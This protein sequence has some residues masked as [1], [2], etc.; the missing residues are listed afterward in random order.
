MAMWMMAAMIR[1]NF[2]SIIIER[3]MRYYLIM[4]SDP[5]RSEDDKPNQA[6]FSEEYLKHQL[7]K[8]DKMTIQ[9]LLK[10]RRTVEETRLDL[11]KQQSIV[12]RAKQLNKQFG[13]ENKYLGQRT[14]G[15][16]WTMMN[17]QV[18]D[19][20]AVDFQQQT[21]SRTLNYAKRGKLGIDLFLI[22]FA[23]L[24]VAGLPIYFYV[25]GRKQRER[26][27]KNRKLT[28]KQIRSLDEDSPVNIDEV[29][30][31]VIMYYNPERERMMLKQLEML[32]KHER[33][34]KEI[35]EM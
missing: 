26:R 20:R 3:S 30:E 16:V 22:A 5:S 25:S 17:Q 4:S 33:I 15:E 12:S 13:V 7:A 34:M 10:S 35:E 29:S 14:P 8:I 2:I 1:C 31:Q 11:T 21:R 6:L 27:V 19:M 32:Q 28:P 9:D 24:G 18:R 23:I